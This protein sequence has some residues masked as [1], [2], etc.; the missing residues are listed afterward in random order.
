MTNGHIRVPQE[1]V[2]K[3]KELL[4]QNNMGYTD[5]GKALG[6]SRNAVSGIVRR[7]NLSTPTRQ[8]NR[9]HYKAY[10][11]NNEKFHK[12]KPSVTPKKPSYTPGKSQGPAYEVR[13][14]Q[15]KPLAQNS[16][17]VSLLKVKEVQCKL[18]I[19]PDVESGAPDFM[20]CG[21]PKNSILLP[22]CDFHMEMTS[23]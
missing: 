11:H 6:I 1:K 18:P 23:R 16:E 20:C 12:Q 9:G 15:P 7:Y 21:A 5:I 3:I 8:A 13:A 14:N 22:Y 19:W 4:A 17:P 2:D 10:N